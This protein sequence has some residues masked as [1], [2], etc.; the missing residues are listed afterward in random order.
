MLSDSFKIEVVEEE[1]PGA[2]LEDDDEDRCD[3]GNL[4]TFFSFFPLLFLVNL[5]QFH[6]FTH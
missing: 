5:I 4:V 1:L 6:T 3:C 2:L